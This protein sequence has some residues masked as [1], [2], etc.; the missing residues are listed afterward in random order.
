MFL[1]ND[2]LLGLCSE[3]FTQLPVSVKE[4]IQITLHNKQ[5]NINGWVWDEIKWEFDYKCKYFI[6]L[7]YTG[8]P[9][10]DLGY[11]WVYNIITGKYEE[12]LTQYFLPI[13]P[14][15]QTKT[16]GSFEDVLQNLSPVYFNK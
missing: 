4:Y 8:S 15:E 3:A 11:V 7:C 12:Y 16:V 13:T 2:D 1:F 6:H 9:P 5:A 10:R 14:I